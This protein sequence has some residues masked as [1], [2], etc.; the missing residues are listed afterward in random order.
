[1]A[2]KFDYLWFGVSQLR[3]RSDSNLYLDLVCYISAPDDSCFSPAMLTRYD[4]RYD[5]RAPLF[6]PLFVFRLFLW[7]HHAVYPDYLFLYLIL[8]SC[9]EWWYVGEIPRLI[10]WKKG[11]GVLF[12]RYIRGMN[13]SS[14]YWFIRIMIVHVRSCIYWVG[15]WNCWN[16]FSEI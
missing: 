5:I 10:L 14:E 9:K 15:L 7:S 3:L 13:A 16:A 2:G 8:F 1:M 6:L 11:V 12:E 4:M